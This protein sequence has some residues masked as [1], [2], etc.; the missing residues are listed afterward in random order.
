[1]YKTV[2]TE[3]CTIRAWCAVVCVA[4]STNSQHIAASHW[5]V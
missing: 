5:M 2:H 3:V 4:I 1:M